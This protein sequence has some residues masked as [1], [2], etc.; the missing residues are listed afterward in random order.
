MSTK[1][2]KRRR[3]QPSDHGSEQ[4]RLHAAAAKCFGIISGGDPHASEKVS[5]T[6]RKRL[7]ERQKLGRV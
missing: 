5:E 1:A 6:V 4:A 7:L 2:T 3:K